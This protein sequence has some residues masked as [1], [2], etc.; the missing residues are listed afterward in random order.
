VNLRHITIPV[1]GMDCA[2]CARSIEGTLTSL[3]GISSATVD[4]L[5]GK[6]LVE[7]TEGFDASKAMQMIRAAGYEPVVETLTLAVEGMTCAACVKHV[8]HALES[9]PWVVSA[10]V[11]LATN[12]ASLS[13]IGRTLDI[14]AVNA[15]LAREGEYSAKLVSDSAEDI[16]RQEQVRLR[17]AVIRLSVSVVLAAFVVAMAMGGMAFGMHTS[18]MRWLEFILSIPV[19]F[20][21]GWP[22]LRGMVMSARRLRADMNTLVGLGASAAFWFSTVSLIFPG[23]LPA[24]MYVRGN[25]PL[26]FETC[27]AIIALI[28]VGK[29]IEEWTKGKTSGSLRKLMKLAPPT[30]RVMRDGV[31]VEI[32][33]AEILV[34][35]IVVVRPGE[36]IAADGT[37]VDGNSA[38]DESMVTG[39]PIPVEKAPG[40]R[41]IT[42]TVNTYG[43]FTFKAEQV[44]SETVLSQVIALVREAQASKAPIQGLADAISAIFVPVVLVIAAL[45][46]IAW[47]VFG[48]Q[49]VLSHAI[50][51]AI[52]VLIVSC[53]CA[54]G[55]ATPAALVVGIGKAAE[56]GILVRN[57]EALEMAGKAEVVLLDK[58][59]VITE[60]RPE[61]REVITQAGISANELLQLAASLEVS[62]EHPL[63]QAVVRRADELK[64]ARTEIHEFVS[65]AGLGVSGVIDGVE[66]LA[67]NAKFLIERSIALPDIGAGTQIFVARAGKL[68]GTILLEDRTRADSPDAIADLKRMGMHTII[69]TG[70]NAASAQ[71]IVDEV[72][73]D[74]VFAGLMPGDKAAKVAEVKARGKRVLMIGDGI[75]DAPALAAADIGIAVGRGT[76]IAI[77]SAGIVLL[78]NSLADAVRAIRI[79]RAT[80]AVIRQNLFWAFAYNV[81]LIPIAAGVLALFHGPQM[82]PML[83]ALAMAFSSVTVVGNSLRLRLF[84]L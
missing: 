24:S 56:G 33:I 65:H 18:L 48:P 29:T 41:V 19:Y 69:I 12:T 22:F 66:V 43:A 64:L 70:D 71:R 61:V 77:E 6:A 23:T 45:S 15:A 83:A 52:S 16:E 59:G 81:V 31:E 34:G 20:Y 27:A 35:D 51:A 39:E 63:A 5:N 21:G 7:V 67:G 62:S 60:G 9:F 47:M 76:D 78:R 11:S 38:L 79:S 42:G 32:P 40:D 13:I 84:R 68:L 49:P 14:R 54:L 36:R 26:Y 1:K 25:S 46:F 37:L 75:N 28:L 80:M 58:T 53:P 74:E 72:R 55:L 73:A 8:T 17:R 10:S 57:G 50:I 30:A 44:G 2:A 4:Y 3:P 82:Q